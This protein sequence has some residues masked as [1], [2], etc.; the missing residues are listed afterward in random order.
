MTQQRC[1]QC[2]DV[3]PTSEFRKYYRNNSNGHY[4]VC[5]SCE[6]INSRFKYLQSKA[7]R[8]VATESDMTQ[9][10]SIHELYDVL[11]KHGLCPPEFGRLA[12]GGI[13]SNR[14]ITEQLDRLQ[15]TR[16]AT[17]VVDE[18]PVTSESGTPAELDEWLTKDLTS[19]EP[20][21]L[22]DEIFEQLQATYRPQVGI[23]SATLLPE[24]D[25]TYREILNAILKRFDEYEESA[26]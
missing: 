18:R 3:K 7:K 8:D 20:E 15:G 12:T 24:Y 21:Y 2:G 5:L 13:V 26:L 22:Q 19:Y 1:K 4:K 9:L 16:P 17:I 14:L 6:T 25:D 10:R 11:R 23:N